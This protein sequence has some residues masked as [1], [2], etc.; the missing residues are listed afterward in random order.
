[1]T[2][3]L[4]LVPTGLGLRGRRRRRSLELRNGDGVL[5]ASPLV[6]EGSAAI[7]QTVHDSLLFGE[8]R[9]VCPA[10]T[11]EELLLVLASLGLGGRRRRRSLEL[12]DGNGVLLTGPLVLEGST[13]ILQTVHDFLLISVLQK[14]CRNAALA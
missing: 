14:T 2:S 9:N 11:E 5:F 1:M 12:R 3:G 13:A 4:L 6:F 10:R 8:D 7:F